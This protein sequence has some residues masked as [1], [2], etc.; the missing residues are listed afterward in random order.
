M[1]TKTAYVAYTNT[2]LTAGQGY[3]IPA[4]LCAIR[5]TAVR[6]AKGINVQGSDG[7]VKE[8]SLVKVDGMWYAPIG[9][10]VRLEQP[11]TKD[12]DAQKEYD[13]RVA[14]I[15]KAR[16][17]GLTEEDLASLITPV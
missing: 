6:L 4:A 13:K 7:P 17:A 2:D 12:L 10:A 9:T 15:E 11:L 8:V 1:E 5:A 14:V 16:A 3:Q